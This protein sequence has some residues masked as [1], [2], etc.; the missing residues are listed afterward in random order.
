MSPLTVAGAHAPA[1]Y[2]N[3]DG[4][5]SSTPLCLYMGR[6]Q[7]GSSAVIYP[8]TGVVWNSKACSEITWSFVKVSFQLLRS[9][10]FGLLA[11][12]ASFAI[13]FQKRGGGTMARG[14]FSSNAKGNLRKFP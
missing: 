4:A 9:N 6:V 1:T 11:C 12:V 13:F 14:I 5:V 7:Y 10:N 8:L 3:G 2:S